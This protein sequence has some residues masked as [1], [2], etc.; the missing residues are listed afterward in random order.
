VQ[1]TR[2]R[3]VLLIAYH[4]PPCATSSGVQRSLSFSLHLGTHGW[5]PVVLTAQPATYERTDYHQLQ[6][7]PADLP[8][9]RTR[10][11]DAAR[12]LAFHG[13]YWSRLALPDRWIS[14]WLTAVPHGLA[15]IRRHRVDVIWSTYPI[16]TAHVIGA[17]LARLSGLPWIADFRDPMVERVAHTGELFPKDPVLR[18]SR[19]KTEAKA[20]KHAARLVFCTDAARRI[21]LDRYAKVDARRL[22]VISNGFDEGAFR[23]AEERQR[24]AAPASV[25][26]ERPDKRVLLHSGTIYPGADRD[27]TD[28]MK[29]LKWLAGTGVLTGADFE[30]RLRDPA[31]EDYFRNLAANLGVESLISILPTLPYREALA[32][33]LAADALLLLQGQTSNPAVPAKLYEYLR[34]RRPILALVH[35]AGETAATLRGLGIDSMASLNDPDAI[36]QLL[37][38]WLKDPAQL[39]SG[40]PPPAT[41]AEYS[42]ERLTA[43]LAQLLDVAVE[44]GSPTD[45]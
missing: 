11:L 16:A 7:I 42:R 19:L 26:S 4:Y 36:A 27:P 24:H 20:V 25:N 37:S 6:D 15:L 9:T 18:R 3:A 40:L 23:Q 38:R 17:T 21:V 33:M 1:E 22:E 35:P 13:R 28:L 31:N 34:A 8:V 39:E 29:A 41:V 14:W 43:Q 5:R 10:A 44:Q 12:D 2:A 45:R 30:L 32:E